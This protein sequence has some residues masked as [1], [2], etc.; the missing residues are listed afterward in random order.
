MSEEGFAVNDLVFHE[1]N[2]KVAAGGYVI[3]SQILQKGGAAIKNLNVSN[4]NGLQKM[5]VPAGL[6]LIHRNKEIN[7]NLN[8]DNHVSEIGKTVNDGIF[9]NLFKMLGGRKKKRK[10]RR[11]K[12]R[13]KKSKRTTRKKR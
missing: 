8:M 4:G 7:D 9:D 12:K 1:K 3:N 2:G 11:A 10:T 6:F 13:S 5:A